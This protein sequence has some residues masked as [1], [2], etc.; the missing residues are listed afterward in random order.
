MLRPRLIP[1]LLV[2]NKGL[3]K[4]VNFRPGKYV[5]DPIN[6]V[7]IFN[8]KEVDELIVLDIGATREAREPDYGL[9]ERLARECRMPLCYG[10]GIKTVD[11]AQRIFGLGVEKIAIGSAAIE[12]PSLV[13]ETA[14]RVGGQSV[15]VV[16]DVKKDLDGRSYRI[17]V[18]NGTTDTGRDPSAYA[19]LMERAGAGEI[20]VNSIDR[21]G[22]MRGYDLELIGA[23]RRSVGIPI[24]AVGGAGSMDDIRELIDR[25]GIMGAAAGSLFVFKGRYR[26]VLIN[27]PSRADRDALSMNAAINRVDT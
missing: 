14:E 1:C 6:T 26:A 19:V 25:F 24:S 13:A 5:G 16:M 27:Y 12:D 22:T 17:W 8:E 20:V 10:G 18:R 11:Q 3:V 2:D 9:I 7:R 15:V 21:D 4:T 23:V